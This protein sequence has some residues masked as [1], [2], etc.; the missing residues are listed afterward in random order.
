[1]GSHFGTAAQ[2]STSTPVLGTSRIGFLNF[3][4]PIFG[5]AAQK[6]TRPRF[7]HPKFNEKS[8]I[9][10]YFGRFFG[11]TAQI[12]LDA[13]WIGSHPEHHEPKGA[14]K[15]ATHHPNF[16]HITYRVHLVSS[17]HKYLLIGSRSWRSR[18]RS[19]MGSVRS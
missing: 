19:W 16:G 17:K 12:G 8:R 11:T 10:G 5:T 7:G 13:D 14:P 1:M 2:K 9:F 18:I 6:L 3:G 4:G 15:F